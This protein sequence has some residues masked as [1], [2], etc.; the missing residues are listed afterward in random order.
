MLLKKKLFL[1]GWV[2]RVGWLDN[3]E[4]RLNSAQL[5]LELGNKYQGF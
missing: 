4:I 1:S 2:G 5:E 3:L